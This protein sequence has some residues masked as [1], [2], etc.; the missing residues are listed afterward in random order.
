MERLTKRGKEGVA[1]WNGANGVHYSDNQGNIYGNAITKL[2]EYEDADEQGFL[3]RTPCKI[4]ETVWDIDMKIPCAYRI[5]GFSFGTG[6]DYIDE[7]VTEKEIV[8]YYRSSSGIIT[9]SFAI[10][11][12]GKTIFLTKEEAEAALERM[13]EKENEN[14]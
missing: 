4:G 9:G 12:I 1:Y 13:S 11:E 3:L 7:P 6:E 5:T 10:S 14:E 2:A 8:F